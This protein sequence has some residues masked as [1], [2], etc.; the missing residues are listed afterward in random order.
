MARKYPK[1]ADPAVS[2]DTKYRVSWWTKNP[3]TGSPVWNSL[4]YDD[5]GGARRAFK[6]LPA[7]CE[8]S[9][10][11]LEWHESTRSWVAHDL[12]GQGRS[13]AEARADN[14]RGL[15]MLRSVLAHKRGI[16]TRGSVKPPAPFTLKELLGNTADTRGH[17][18]RQ[19]AENCPVC[20]RSMREEQ[21]TGDC[22]V[23][24]YLCQHGREPH[25]PFAQLTQGSLG[26]QL[27]ERF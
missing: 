6:D 1:D 5:I 19:G 16:D 21:N 23:C 11:R 13:P 18:H 22:T 14:A 4:E 7:D 20:S 12:V 17:D 25:H 3:E 10:E 27:E 2:H 15:A 26:E 24:D 8:P 9:A